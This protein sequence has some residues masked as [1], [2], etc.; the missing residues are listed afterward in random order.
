[1][2]GAFDL[3]V[4]G[5][6]T[7]RQRYLVEFLA[8]RDQN[9]PLAGTFVT[10]Y[11]L[12][13]LV[14][15][16]YT[17]AYADE[18]PELLEGL[19]T[20]ESLQFF[21]LSELRVTGDE[22]AQTEALL[23][24]ARTYWYLNQNRQPAPGA[25]PPPAVHHAPPQE[26][27]YTDITQWDGDI[28]CAVDTHRGCPVYVR[29]TGRPGQSALWDER[30][31][32]FQS[33][34][35]YNDTHWTGYDMAAGCW[36]F[37]PHR[38]NE[39]P[40]E[41]LP[42]WTTKPPGGDATLA[43]REA[44]EFHEDVLRLVTAVSTGAVG[45]HQLA[46]PLQHAGTLMAKDLGP[47]SDR[48]RAARVALA[49]PADGTGLGEAGKAIH[50]LKTEMERLAKGLEG[51]KSWPKA[52]GLDKWNV[53]PREYVSMLRLGCQE[54]A[55]SVRRIHGAPHGGDMLATAGQAVGRSEDEVRQTLGEVVN[56]AWAMGQ[57]DD[58]P[59]LTFANPLHTADRL[60]QMRY[61][62]EGCQDLTDTVGTY[63][64][65]YG[66]EF[67]EGK[68]TGGNYDYVLREAQVVLRRY[69]EQLVTLGE[70]WPQWDGDDPLPVESPKAYALMMGLGWQVLEAERKELRTFVDWEMSPCNPN[71]PA[72]KSP[73]PRQ[74]AKA[75]LEAAKP[76]KPPV[77]LPDLDEV[78]ALVD[79]MVSGDWH[80]E[81][82][83]HPLGLV[84]RWRESAGL[85]ADFP[86]FHE[87]A[88]GVAKCYDRREDSPTE[89][90]NACAGLIGVMEALRVA[91]KL[92]GRGWPATW[93]EEG[94]KLPQQSPAAVSLLIEQGQR[95][96]RRSKNN[97]SEDFKK[98]FSASEAGPR[99]SR[100][101]G[102]AHGRRRRV[103]S[104][105]PGGR[106]RA[107]PTTPMDSFRRF[108][109]GS[110]R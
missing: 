65:Q 74:L 95:E 56:F 90:E 69:T 37:L 60:A 102:G 54:L 10:W 5:R 64:A 101:A 45:L 44:P 1:M 25:A 8:D 20:A 76:P 62:Q 9:I 96:L 77:E 73:P 109:F 21:V 104:A 59:S 103:K 18:M 84:D 12:A 58:C 88:A 63:L 43:K 3:D 93:V 46:D 92:M 4:L 72:P 40:D 27:R 7:E 108:L 57:Q 82:L 35:K 30:R 2:Q 66:T 81:G 83:A 67:R 80:A 26:R 50:G 52:W 53:A 24:L 70:R 31:P 38:K 14:R 75:R 106:R 107:K 32:R 36:M 55:G 15:E 41:H 33:L 98:R 100:R 99:T 47:L 42:G 17:G 110:G 89:Y 11:E 49:G 94:R 39:T 97:L 16:F 91:L 19:D 61:V 34:A 29:S 28:W 68:C 71:M 79:D 85:L 22:R 6:L 13:V 48:A 78:R 23:E 51:M 86:E 105:P 87:R